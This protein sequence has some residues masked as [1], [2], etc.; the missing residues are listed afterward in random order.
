MTVLRSKVKPQ[1][2]AFQAAA[3][4]M[5]ALVDDLNVR[6]ATAREGDRKSVV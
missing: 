4:G 5:R 3:Q 2:Q 1:S 6:L